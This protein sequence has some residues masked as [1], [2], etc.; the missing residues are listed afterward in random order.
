MKYIITENRLHNIISR[1]LEEK[2]FINEVSF[3]KNDRLNIYV[4][5]TPSLPS[6]NNLAYEIRTLFEFKGPITFF[7]PSKTEG[8]YLMFA[9]Y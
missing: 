6:L 1:Y 3:D 5:K 8:H 9:Q 2:D 7:R 4:L